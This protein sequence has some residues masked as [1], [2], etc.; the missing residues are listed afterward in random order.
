MNKKILDY[1]K[2]LTSQDKKSLSQKTLKAQ[3]ELG[4]LAKAVLPYENAAACTHRF[5][6]KE[7]ILEECVDELLCIYSIIYDVGFNDD[8]IL[9]MMDRKANKWAG[10]LAREGRIKYPVPFEIH[11]TIEQAD[12]ENFKSSCKQIGVK[13]ILL[14]LHLS[15]D[16]VMKDLMTS[17]VFRGNN[18][19][20]Y[21]ETKR[22]SSALGARGFKVIREKIETVPWHPA[23]PCNQNNNTFMPENCYFESHLNV[24]VADA[25]KRELLKMVAVRHG[26]KLSNNVFKKLEDGKFTMMVTHRSYDKVYEEFYKD[27]QELVLDIKL[28]DFQI[29]K[30]I[31]EFSIYDTKVSHD[32]TWISKSEITK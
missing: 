18:R 30:E 19:E 20:A 32:A 14:D 24:V 16:G 13:P 11:V 28:N 6:E 17:S 12:L 4:E 7:K 25:E 8:E 21:E 26:A 23:A 29:E 15:N 5:I 31:I 3:E 1:I 2:L 22:I 27:L 10:L 9:G